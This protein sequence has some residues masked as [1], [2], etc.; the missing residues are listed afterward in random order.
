VPD[1]HVDSMILD[2]SNNLNLSY[3]NTRDDLVVSL[4]KY[5]NAVPDPIDLSEYLRIED[6]VPDVHVSLVFDDDSDNI[7]LSYNDT[8]DDLVVSLAKY[9]NVLPDPVD[10][11]VYLRIEDVVPDVHVN[12]VF[13]DYSDN[14]T[15]SYINTRDDL[16][17]SLAK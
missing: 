13:I 15:L 11:S 7:N 9:A 5:V 17:V 3:N 2:D 14:L 6:V 1:V 8:R 16:V 4:A 10:L 12:L